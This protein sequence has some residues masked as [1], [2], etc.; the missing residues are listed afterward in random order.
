MALP[1]LLAVLLVFPS[2]ARARPD[3]G[4]ELK[5]VHVLVVID[6]L[7]NLAKELRVDERNFLNLFT[8]LVPANRYQVTVLKG[9]R[10]S[11][12]S[13]HEYYRRLSVAPDEGVVCYYG[14]HG[15]RTIANR[16][17]LALYNGRFYR[18]ELLRTMEGK[19]A[20]LTV[21]LTDCCSNIPD[22]EDRPEKTFLD[23]KEK[24]GEEV[25]TLHPT[26]RRLFFQARG[27]VDIT[28]ATGNEAFGQD[29]EGG[30]FT[31]AL[32]KLARAR[33][34]GLE[35]EADGAGCWKVFF[36]MLQKETESL[37]RG[38]AEKVRSLG[39]KLAASTQ[40]PQ[41][42][43]LGGAVNKP[44]AVVSLVNR[45]GRAVRYRYRWSSDSNWSVQVLPPGGRMHHE[46]RLPATGSVFFF[47]EGDP[48]VRLPPVLY[49]ATWSGNGR[50]GFSDGRKYEILP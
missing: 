46:V 41:A 9:S 23:W 11:P 10:V 37:F 19:R 13:I 32:C 24:A 22:R 40:R 4:P 16:H 27:T 1:G 42:F 3:G 18:D 29:E 34:P 8:R 30:L 39:D 38:Y 26:I 45:S 36:P 33:I 43:S 44:Q 12:D 49:P 47:V 7:S 35:R 21:L 31:R 48:Q 20:A 17:Y 2:G 6:T 25:K 5:K 50:P 14:G 28:A 15:G